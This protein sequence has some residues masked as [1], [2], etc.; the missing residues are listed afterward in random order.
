MRR[1]LAA[2]VAGL[3]LLTPAGVLSIMS[4]QPRA[5]SSRPNA[6]GT[7]AT[8][9][10][11]QEATAFQFLH[12]HIEG[13]SRVNEAINEVN[14]VA[15]S[16]S[17]VDQMTANQNA[18]IAVDM[19]QRT[20]RSF[21]AQNDSTRHSAVGAILSAYDMLR[22]SLKIQLGLYETLDSAHTVD[23][24]RGV[25]LRMSSAKVA[26][27][28]GSALLVEATTM[29]FLSTMVADSSDL[30]AP[31][32]LDMTASERDSLLHLLDSSFGASIR[33]SKGWRERSF[34]LSPAPLDGTSG[35]SEACSVVPG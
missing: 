22:Q 29:A 19:T 30:N 4:C 34:G 28:Q 13:L 12:A 15:S 24:L 25:R 23:D 9:S 32:Q 11:P 26:Y 35:R 7:A 5:V 16:T 17:L 10:P 18:S 27:Q 33:K 31:V 14:S 20:M 3:L 1:A 8:P 6:S 21:D 2:L